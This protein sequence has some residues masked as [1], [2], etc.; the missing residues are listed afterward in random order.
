MSLLAGLTTDEPLLAFAEPVD[1]DRTEDIV[2]VLTGG[3]NRS[4]AASLGCRPSF[5][6]CFA[7][8]GALAKPTCAS[9]V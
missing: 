4:T 5:Q 6:T 9:H 3:P 7:Q 1:D 2:Q 8:A